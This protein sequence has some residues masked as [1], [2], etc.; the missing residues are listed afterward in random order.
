MIRWLIFIGFVLFIDFYAFQSVKTI[1]KNKI[2]YV[3]YWLI[4]AAVIFNVIYSIK[5]IGES[6]GLSQQVMF[7]F[8]LLIL[9]IIV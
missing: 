6:R 2:V 7:A 4:S 8:G 3:V 9:S 5:S 1:T